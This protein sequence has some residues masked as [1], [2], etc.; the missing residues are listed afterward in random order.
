MEAAPIQQSV[1]EERNGRFTPDSL[2]SFLSPG[3]C[4]Q[5]S[6]FIP[7]KGL[8]PNSAWGKP[9][10][11]TW[12]VCRSRL[13]TPY[14]WMKAFFFFYSHVS[15]PEMCPESKP[16]LKQDCLWCYRHRHVLHCQKQDIYVVSWTLRVDT[17]LNTTHTSLLNQS[18]AD[19]HSNCRKFNWFY[20]QSKSS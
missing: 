13:G 6:S 7:R 3:L 18:S 12:Q 10:T 11:Q 4:L 5:L 16:K 19:W 9:L 17:E 20:F 14:S 8:E 2:T 1:I 15:S